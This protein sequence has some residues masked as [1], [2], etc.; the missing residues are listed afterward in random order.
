MFAIHRRW[1]WRTFMLLC[2]AVVLRMLGGLATVVHFDAVWLY[3]LSVWL[4]WTVPLLALEASRLLRV[5][6]DALA[7][8]S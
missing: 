4:S 8:T 1:M 5:P 2:S 7:P 6:T 3:P